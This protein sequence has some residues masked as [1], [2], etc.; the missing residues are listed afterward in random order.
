MHTYMQYDAVPY[1]NKKAPSK[2]GACIQQKRVQKA[3]GC[4]FILCAI[5]PL[6]FSLRWLLVLPSSFIAGALAPII[7]QIFILNYF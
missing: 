6:H 7:V 5:P 2:D 4:Y 3:G 1:T